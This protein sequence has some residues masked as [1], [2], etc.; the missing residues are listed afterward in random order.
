MHRQKGVRN[1][2]IRKKTVSKPSYGQL[3]RLTIEDLPDSKRRNMIRDVQWLHNDQ[4]F[5]NGLKLALMNNSFIA[6]EHKNIE[7]SIDQLIRLINEEIER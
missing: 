2:E 4:T 7:K 6:N 1:F 5:N 3:H